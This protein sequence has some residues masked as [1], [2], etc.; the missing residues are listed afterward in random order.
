MSGTET[1]ICL[2]RVKKGNERKFERLLERHWPALRALG[3]V[4]RRRARH[5]RGVEHDG[6]PIFVEMFDWISGEASE[7]AHTH[8]EIAAIWEPMDALCES[9]AGRPNMEF[10]HVQPL[11]ILA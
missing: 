8:A 5:F 1:V 10:P 3:L 4:T 6:E 2:Y 9:R 7:K 11:E